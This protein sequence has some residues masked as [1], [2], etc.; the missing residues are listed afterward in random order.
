VPA[1]TGPEYKPIYSSV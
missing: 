1:K